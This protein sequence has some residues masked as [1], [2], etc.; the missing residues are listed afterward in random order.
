MTEERLQKI[1]A[2]SGYGSRRSC[3]D[4]ITTGRVI[5]NGQKAEL[6]QKADPEKDRI[7]VDRSRIPQAT[8]MVYMA[9]NKPRF[10]L[11]DKVQG[12]ERRSVF[13]MVPGGSELSIVGRLDFESE[14]LVLLTN[15][16]DM[17]NKLTH[18][19]YEHEKEY[20][21]LLASKPD[22]KQLEAWRR[23]LILEDGHRTSPAKVD[24]DT[25]LG[26]GAWLRI[27]MK[28]GHKRQIR[29]SAKLLGLFVIR[30]LRVRIGTIILGT[31]KSGEWRELSDSEVKS[32][33]SGTKPERKAGNRPE[34]KFLRKP[35][36]QTD[37]EH[38][39]KPVRR[40]Q[41]A[42]QTDR[43][44]TKKPVRRSQT[45]PQTDGE[46]TKKPVRRIQTSSKTDVEF[47]KKP[48]RRSQTKK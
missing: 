31:L 19:R 14:G 43:E 9:Y 8:P 34:R 23:G 18:P 38:S 41:T 28:E 15:D 27:V 2:R 26:K 37:G 46:Y 39:K 7:E 45:A 42:L 17:V 1:L 47:T 4:L 29:E 5:V 20:K 35:A 22:M 40:S 13:E 25:P 12:D 30:I 32:L 6:G 21:V 33:K 10:M 24:I 16:G 44:Y 11:C 48:V 3:E 36:L